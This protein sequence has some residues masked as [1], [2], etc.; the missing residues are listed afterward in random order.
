MSSHR[1]SAGVAV[2]LVLAAVAAAAPMKALVVDGQNGHN[3]KETTPILKGL[4][5]ETGLFTVGRGH[6]AAARQG[7]ER[8][9]A[10]LR[11]L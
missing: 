5:E 2:W 3:W 6:L 10:R 11:R 4:L 1:F 9:P 8:L 7:H